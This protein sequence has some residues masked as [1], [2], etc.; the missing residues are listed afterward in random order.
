LNLGQPLG[1]TPFR[2]S[3]RMAAEGFSRVD[4]VLESQ[5]IVQRLDLF[6]R[7]SV[8]L[9]SLAGFSLAPSIGFRQT[10]Y[11]ARV[12]QEP[13]PEIVPRSLHREYGIFELDIK[14][15]TLE[16]TF[17][18]SRLGTLKHVVEP[19]ITYRR[20]WGVEDLS[21]VIRFDENDAVAETLMMREQTSTQN[22]NGCETPASQL[23]GSGKS[24]SW[25]ARISRPSRSNRAHL[26]AIT[27][28][29]RPATA[30][31][32]AVSPQASHS[33]TTS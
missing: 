8:R 19:V 31:R 20:I 27:S 30:H 17:H 23:S 32:R 12:Q 29:D 16:K 13:D 14:T 2:L 26:R 3:F 5:K 18:S 28:R 33:A 7:I 4:S 21:Q 25:R 24:C 15:P 9:P 6:P 11:S 22:C 1:K 10:Y